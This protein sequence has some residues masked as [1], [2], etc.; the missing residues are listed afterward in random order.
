MSSGPTHSSPTI[1]RQTVMLQHFTQN[2]S[3]EAV[4]FVEEFYF[5]FFEKGDNRFAIYIVMPSQVVLTLAK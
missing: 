4:E 5:D 2:P 1:T 3:D